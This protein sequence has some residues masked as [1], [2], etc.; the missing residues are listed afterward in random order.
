MHVKCGWVVRQDKRFESIEIASHFRSTILTLTSQLVYWQTVAG[1]GRNKPQLQWFR[2]SVGHMNQLREP[3]FDQ[4]IRIHET[5]DDWHF[6]L[7]WFESTF[8]HKNTEIP[9]AD[10]TS[11][12]NANFG[13]HRENYIFLDIRG[14]DGGISGITMKAHNSVVS[15]LFAHESEQLQ[16]I[17]S[18]V[19]LLTF[20]SAA[21]SQTLWR[22]KLGDLN[23]STQLQAIAS[24]L[25]FDLSLKARSNGLLLVGQ[26]SHCLEALRMDGVR[27]SSVLHEDTILPS[28]F[29]PVCDTVQDKRF[30]FLAFLAKTKHGK[31]YA[32]SVWGLYSSQVCL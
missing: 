2:P 15:W 26:H 13:S 24:N 20:I 16:E 25:F 17:S 11:D 7:G 8:V 6:F 3:F 29:F 5:N 12:A 9:D 10:L 27:G 30:V 14:C 31:Q 18:I 1:K 4:S 22:K 28:N 19:W 21:E 32:A 23:R